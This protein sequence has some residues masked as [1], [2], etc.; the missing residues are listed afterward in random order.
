MITSLALPV[1]RFLEQE[2]PPESALADVRQGDDSAEVVIP[3]LGSVRVTSEGIDI[4]GPRKAHAGL[5]ARLLRW[6]QAQWLLRQGFG[7]M[8]GTAVA[9]SGRGLMITGSGRSGVSLLALCLVRSGFSLI[10]DGIMAWD[11]N[12]FLLPMTS[13]IVIDELAAQK[14]S[15]DLPCRPVEAGRPVIEVQPDRSPSVAAHRALVLTTSGAISRAVVLEPGSCSTIMEC[16]ELAPL[17]S[18]LYP[19]A[20]R[21]PAPDIPTWQLTRPTTADPDTIVKHSPARLV[22]ALDHLIHEF[23]Q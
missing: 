7:V 23:V 8:S 2:S 15:A 14:M 5:E 6:A 16:E 19:D 20:S 18:L 10:S 12:G 1:P 17:P 9:M 21:T 4:C 22:E 11:S 13:G 3:A